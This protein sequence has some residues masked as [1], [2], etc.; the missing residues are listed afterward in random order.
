[1]WGAGVYTESMARTDVLI[2]PLGDERFVPGLAEELARNGMGPISYA[3]VKS[4]LPTHAMNPNL[5]GVV[6]A[7][8]E[9]FEREMGESGLERARALAYMA[10]QEEVPRLVVGRLYQMAVDEI[11][12]RKQG[13]T[14]E[15]MGVVGWSPQVVRAVVGFLAR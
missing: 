2:T 5:Q 12:E 13:G 11:L 6:I 15:I 9:A 1:M 7:S 4:C 14:T 8:V 3:S 10:V